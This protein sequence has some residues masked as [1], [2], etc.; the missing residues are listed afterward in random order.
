MGHRATPTEEEQRIRQAT[1]EAHET[2]QALNDAIKEARTLI[3]DVIN[4]FEQVAAR[5]IAD[6]GA[7][8]Q[9]NNN[10]AA[11]QLNRQVQA[12]RDHIVHLLTISSIKPDPE[13]NA[14]I[15]EFPPGG[16]DDQ[17]PAPAARK[18]TQKGTS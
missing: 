2:L 11:A 15:V 8:L 12:A 13:Q 17:I 3:S 10:E 7:H 9:R 14:F 18:P 6:L 16:F 5:E 1:R 4:G